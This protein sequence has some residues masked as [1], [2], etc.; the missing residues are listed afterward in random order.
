MSHCT[1]KSTHIPSIFHTSLYLHV[2]RCG[3]KVDAVHSFDEVPD[4]EVKERFEK[5]FNDEI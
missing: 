1:I 3:D 2:A 5:F 4:E